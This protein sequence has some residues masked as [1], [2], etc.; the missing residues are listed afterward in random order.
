MGRCQLGSNCV[1]RLGLTNLVNELTE[2][3]QLW[4]YYAE[5][6]LILLMPKSSP[7]NYNLTPYFIV[8][9]KTSHLSY[10]MHDDSA[11]H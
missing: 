8:Q 3:Q 4:D 10:T 5:E 6:Q 2:R 11:V 7:S 1:K 9:Q